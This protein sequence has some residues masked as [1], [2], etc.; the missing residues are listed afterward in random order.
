L[1]LKLKGRFDKLTEI[2]K[3]EQNDST[4]KDRIVTEEITIPSRIKLN[5]FIDIVEAQHD[6]E[7][8]PYANVTTR[9][10][11]D[12]I[13]ININQVYSV[14]GSTELKKNIIIKKGE[15]LPLLRLEDNIEQLDFIKKHRPKETKNFLSL[16]NNSEGLKY[17]THKFNDGKLDYKIFIELCKSEFDKAVT[18][19]PNVPDALL[20]RIEEFSFAPNP[21]WYIRRGNEKIFPKKGWAEASFVEWYKNNI[22]IHP[23]FDSK[24]NNEMIIPF[25]ESIEVRAG[26]LL[27]IIQ[28]VLNACLGESK[29]NFLIK[30]N[31]QN[32]NT[33]EFYTDVDKFKVALFHIISTIKER[34]D[35]NFCFEIEVDFTNESLEGGNFKNVIITHI[36][37]EPT[38][39]SNDKD[40]VK[41]DIKTIQKNLWGLCN[42]EI[43]AKFPDGFRNKIILTDDYNDYKTYVIEGKSIPVCD[44]TSVKGFTHILKFY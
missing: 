29:S 20:R 14:D 37:S 36:N 11:I 34:A 6:V 24:W 7:T 25:K 44:A 2:A 31:D 32:I 8:S 28:E 38:K 26:N 40:F 43:L 17:L 9:K 35:K 27:A 23:G 13:S 19:Y 18:E 22:N 21:E 33:A 39:N 12:K 15:T 10:K 4:I 30:L 16:F 5:S 41:G 42:Y 3:V 1:Y